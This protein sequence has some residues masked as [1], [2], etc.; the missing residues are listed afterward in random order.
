MKYGLVRG[1][2]GYSTTDEQEKIMMKLDVDETYYDPTPLGS[3]DKTLLYKKLCTMEKRDVLIV[4][5]L[6]RLVI[7]DISE[8]IEIIDV[9]NTKGLRFIAVKENIDTFNSWSRDC[10]EMIRILSNITKRLVKTKEEV[11][12]V[13]CDVRMSE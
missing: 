5:K 4:D 2:L 3:K 8:L 6:E 12:D 13:E 7:D 1:I 9:I 10:I 11:G